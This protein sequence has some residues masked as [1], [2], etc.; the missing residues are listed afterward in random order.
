MG[1]GGGSRYGD[2]FVMII[3]RDNTQ[4][5]IDPADGRARK[6]AVGSPYVLGEATGVEGEPGVFVT[7]RRAP[8]EVVGLRL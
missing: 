5:L 3:G 1:G 8:D 4:V 7:T 2:W 6:L